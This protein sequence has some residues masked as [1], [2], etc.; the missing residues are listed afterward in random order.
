[1]VQAGHPAL[2]VALQVRFGVAEASS[3]LRLAET[4]RHDSQRTGQV[5]QVVFV[6]LGQLDGRDDPRPAGSIGK[7]D[8]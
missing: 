8:P 6:E 3:S 5:S 4:G 2:Q 7:G 1:M